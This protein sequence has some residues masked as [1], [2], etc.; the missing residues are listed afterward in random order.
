MIGRG[1]PPP[2]ELLVVI[3]LS[4]VSASAA[5]NSTPPSSYQHYRISGDAPM[6]PATNIQLI[7]LSKK[8][9]TT[10]NA[11]LVHLGLKR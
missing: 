2:R 1:P 3:C 11:V 7:E 9:D 4:L 6:D 5:G 8:R 10:R